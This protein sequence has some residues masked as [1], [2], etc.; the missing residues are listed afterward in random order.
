MIDPYMICLFIFLMEMCKV[1]VKNC[2][3]RRQRM[4]LTRLYSTMASDNY[5]VAFE[6]VLIK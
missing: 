6:Y 3:E 4:L 5:A 1:A 2:C